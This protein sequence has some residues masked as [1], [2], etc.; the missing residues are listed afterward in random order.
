MLREFENIE[1]EAHEKNMPVIA[2]IYP[3]GKS[4]Q[5]RASGELLAYAARVALE[6][7]ADMVK[8]HWNGNEHDLMWA[9]EAAGACNV[10]VAGGLKTTQTELLKNVKTVIATGATGLAIG[11]NVWQA[12]DPL[13]LTRK[14]KEVIWPSGQKRVA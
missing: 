4:I 3:R 2:W 13:E 5:K 7:G 11:R 9:V 6:I 14:I 1:R 8:V 12:R 10:V